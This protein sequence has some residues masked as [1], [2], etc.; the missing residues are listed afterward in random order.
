MILVIVGVPRLA[1]WDQLTAREAHLGWAA[2]EAAN[3]TIDSPDI[4]PDHA[5]AT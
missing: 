4:W 3:R 1:G 5:Q 2:I